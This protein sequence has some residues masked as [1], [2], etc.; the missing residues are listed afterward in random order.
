MCPGCQQRGDIDHIVA[1][2]G[3]GRKAG[4]NEAVIAAIDVIEKQLKRRGLADA[5]ALYELLD[6][7]PS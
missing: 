3:N 1:C 4:W 2:V 5:S 6:R 7:S